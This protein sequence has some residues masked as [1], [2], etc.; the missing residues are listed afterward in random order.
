VTDT[1]SPTLT[2]AGN[3]SACHPGLTK[4][5]IRVACRATSLGCRAVTTWRGC[6]EKHSPG[7]LRC[8]V[9]GRSG[10]FVDPFPPTRSYRS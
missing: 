9:C 7:L 2:S 4:T 10:R 3:I 8:V 1:S 6:S 5:A